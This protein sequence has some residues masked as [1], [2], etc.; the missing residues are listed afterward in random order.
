MRITYSQGLLYISVAGIQI[1]LLQCYI[2]HVDF[3]I[4]FGKYF[5]HI[6]LCK[7]TFF[8]PLYVWLN[9]L[10]WLTFY[11]CSTGVLIM[12]L[13]IHPDIFFK[14]KIVKAKPF[15][16]WSWQKLTYK[17][18]LIFYNLMICLIC[19]NPNPSLG[20][21]CSDQSMWLIQDIASFIWLTLV[22]DLVI[23]LY[24]IPGKW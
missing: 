14:Y 15:S 17:V 13:L 22:T 19:Y 7:Y 4:F 20:W 21:P 8:K 24:R 6:C 23:I 16:T 18:C 11:I 10:I 9:E 2:P 3:L 5:Y 12:R 1:T